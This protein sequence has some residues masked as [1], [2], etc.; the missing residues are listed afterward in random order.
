MSPK[1]SRS[2]GL[3]VLMAAL[4]LQGLSGI[5]GGIGLVLDPSGSS[6]QIP[7][8][9]LAGSP[10]ENYLLPGLI[11]LTVLGFV[12]LVA[13]YGLLQQRAWSWLLA[14]LVGVAL[15]VWI[16]V[17]IA[18]IG[19]QADPPLQ[20]IYGAL[21]IVILVAGALPSTRRGCAPKRKRPPAA[22]KEK[23]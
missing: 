8:S 4:L 5:A 1:R 3:L 10:F 18:I 15:I 12:P 6:L 20:L 9:L 19:Y 14:V 22:R 2:L 17:E 11:L 16:A 7:L 23:T 21:G 13:F